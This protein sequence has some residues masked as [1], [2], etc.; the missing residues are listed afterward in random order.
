M[1]PNDPIP[2][3]AQP[4]QTLSSVVVELDEIRSILKSLVT[5]KASGPDLLNNKL[6]QALADVI[7]APLTDLFNSSLLRATVPEIWKQANVTPVH[8]KDSKSNVENYRP[9]SLLSSVGK[10]FERVIYKRIHNFLLEN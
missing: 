5:G 8:K 7:A 6:L 1:T 10:T 9:I 3:L 2:N 4:E